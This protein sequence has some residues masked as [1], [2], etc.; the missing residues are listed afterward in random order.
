MYKRPSSKEDETAEVSGSRVFIDP[1][2]DTE[3]EEWADALCAD[4]PPM[5]EEALTAVAA[6]YDA[7]EQR[8]IM[9]R[10]TARDGHG[11]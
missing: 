11:L 8:Q 7:I 3:L 2:P 1:E 9:S 6:V 10:R 4:L 5:T